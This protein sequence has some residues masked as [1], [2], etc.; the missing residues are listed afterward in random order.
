VVAST[1]GLPAPHP[2]RVTI[3]GVPSD[4]VRADEAR[5]IVQTYLSPPWDGQLR[6]IVT[7]NPEYVM[8]ASRD[9]AFAA[10]IARA[11]LIT[12]DGI[13]VLLAQRLLRES[14]RA[15]GERVT[16]VTLLEWLLEESSL[17][18]TSLFL[19]GGR[20]G[21]A[22]RLA[23]LLSVR[24]PGSRIAGWW[25][26]GSARPEHDGE[27]LSRI[28]ASGAKVVAVAYGAPGQVI[29]IE[30]NRQALIDAGVRVAIGVGGAFDFLSGDVPRAPVL[31][32]GI[33][34][35]W[36]YRL[37]KEPWRW[38]RQ[39]ILPVFAMRVIRQRFRRLF[40]TGQA[41]EGGKSRMLG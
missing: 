12:A 25:S 23:F 37:V 2:S 6:H 7:L 20:P 10:G 27:A 36:L 38:R 3:L 34:L 40:G 31:L 22:K 33:G 35:E 32:Q 16:G 14:R 1:S 11:D 18:R 29:W 17:T 19:L 15:R 28:R 30:R 41:V 26:E 8:A 5:Q 21:V 39:R 4:I 24:I 13:G 9:P